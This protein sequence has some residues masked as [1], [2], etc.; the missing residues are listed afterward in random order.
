MFGFI[1]VI[2]RQ[3]VSRFW[4]KFWSILKSWT[5]LILLLLLQ[6]EQLKQISGCFSLEKETR[7]IFDS[8][9]DPPQGTHFGADFLHC[10]LK[11]CMAKA[12]FWSIILLVSSVRDSG[13]YGYFINNKSVQVWL[14]LA[15]LETGPPNVT[16]HN[17]HE[18]D[19]TYHRFVVV[20]FKMTKA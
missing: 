8:L 12:R 17:L 20:V 6:L 13:I 16:T 10:W 4:K 11:R 7:V 3:K 14:K 15:R 1:L 19:E 2:K 9:T 5:Q 18:A